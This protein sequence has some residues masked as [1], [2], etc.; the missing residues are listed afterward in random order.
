MRDAVVKCET[1]LPFDGLCLSVLIS[2]FLTLA[3]HGT[4]KT[5]KR[6]YCVSFVTADS[7][8]LT[9]LSA[10]H[11]AISLESQDLIMIDLVSQKSALGTAS[12][13]NRSYATAFTDLGSRGRCAMCC[14]M[15]E[16]L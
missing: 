2:S 4:Q 9:L 11:D 15:E 8:W 1:F 16:G 12:W 3:F 10:K 14:P 7:S 5:K 6:K 13:W